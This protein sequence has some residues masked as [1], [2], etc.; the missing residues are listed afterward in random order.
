MRLFWFPLAALCFAAAPLRSLAQSPVQPD[1]LPPFAQKISLDGINNAG[2]ISDR[3]FRGAQPALSSLRQLKA[4]GVT[5]IVDLRLES[6]QTREEERRLAESLN[7]RFVSIPVGGFSTPSSEQL[8]QFF[9]LLRETPPQSIFV[10]CEFGAD[11]TGVFIAAY[12]IAFQHWTA[13]QAIAEMHAFGFRSFWHPGMTAFVRELPAR[14]QSD[15]TLKA[16]PPA[17]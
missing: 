2:K 6:P 8:A 10:H 5:T 12:R 4:L 3:L 1:P 16:A 14:L 11:R 13:E 15:A 9:S 17:P 7:M